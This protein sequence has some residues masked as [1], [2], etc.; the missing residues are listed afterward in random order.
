MGV[1]AVILLSGCESQ[2]ASI[3]PDTLSDDVIASVDNGTF[4]LCPWA[5]ASAESAEEPLRINVPQTY[6]GDEPIPSDPLAFSVSGDEEY[7]VE[8]AVTRIEC[9]AVGS[10]ID[11]RYGDYLDEYITLAIEVSPDEFD[12]PDGVEETEY[13]GRVIAI[14]TFDDVST[15]IDGHVKATV[16]G[17]IGILEPETSARLLGLLIDTWDDGTLEELIESHAALTDQ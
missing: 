4:P 14:G 6:G 5:A 2:D 8:G 1:V 17:E 16:T 13:K 9:R 15:L 3:L 7:S 11:T 12:V 10:A